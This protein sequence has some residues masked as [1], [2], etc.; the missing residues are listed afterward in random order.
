LHHTG[1]NAWKGH[2]EFMHC[3][4]CLQL[5]PT[6]LP[7]QA[8]VAPPVA[9]LPIPGRGAEAAVV[10]GGG[11][12]GVDFAALITAAV[13]AGAAAANP[14]AQIMPL[15]AAFAG[16]ASGVGVGGQD[17]VA[18]LG[19]GHIAGQKAVA[20]QIVGRRRASIATSQKNLI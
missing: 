5:L 7:T 8:V 11:L 20:E 16:G 15:L 9:L 17:L 2:L 19:V 13:K 10:L 12:G 6:L 18:L 4:Y 14:A 3:R 1:K